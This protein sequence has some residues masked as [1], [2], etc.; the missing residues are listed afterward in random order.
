MIDRLSYRKAAG[1]KVKRG[2]PS[3]GRKP[4]RKKLQRLYIKES[5]SIREVAKVLGC[6]KDMVY[7][8]LQEYGIERRGKTG[9]SKLSS[10]DSAF[11]KKEIKEKGYRKAARDLEIST[12]ALWSYVMRRNI[13]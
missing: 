3:I 6:S 2:R 12:T 1:M 11:L 5:K 13:M 7:R 4:E 8:A 9:N 10:I